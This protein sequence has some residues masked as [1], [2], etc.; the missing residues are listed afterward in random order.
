MQLGAFAPA[1]AVDVS[2]GTQQAMTFP[3]RDFA[4]PVAPQIGRSR[5]RGS[6]IMGKVG[7]HWRNAPRHP[8]DRSPS[9]HPKPATDNARNQIDTNAWRPPCGWRGDR[10]LHGCDRRDKGVAVHPGS[11]APVTRKH[12]D[13]DC[14]RDDGQQLPDLSERAVI[15]PPVLAGELASIRPAPTSNTQPCDGEI[16]DTPVPSVGRRNVPGTNARHSWSYSLHTLNLQDP[17]DERYAQP[18]CAAGEEGET[19]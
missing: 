10:P 4:H 12:Q 19:R 1:V 8:S 15:P 16:S 13:A 7:G 2:A 5:R 17:N 3:R 11:H 6:H 9:R 14:Q 18:G